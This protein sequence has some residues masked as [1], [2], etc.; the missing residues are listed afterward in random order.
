MDPASFCDSGFNA[1]FLN[2]TLLNEYL[3]EMVKLSPLQ[4]YQ[5]EVVSGGEQVA[6]IGAAVNAAAQAAGASL[7]LPRLYCP[8]TPLFLPRRTGNSSPC[9][10]VGSLGELAI[11]TPSV[12][13]KLA[14]CSM[15][16]KSQS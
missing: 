11:S 4:G 14:I 1:R 8:C 16:A 10:H 12:M 15:L 13:P 7:T 3:Q 9:F 2:V 6:T 5:I